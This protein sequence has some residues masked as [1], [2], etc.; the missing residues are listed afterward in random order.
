MGEAKKKRHTAAS[1]QS[2]VSSGGKSRRSFLI[3]LIRL[4]ASFRYTDGRAHAYESRIYRTSAGGSM[5]DVPYV[6][7]VIRICG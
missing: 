1:K 5:C 3:A 7:S 2:K 6:Q 4:A